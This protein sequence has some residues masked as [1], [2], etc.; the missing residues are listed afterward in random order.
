MICCSNVQII[1]G[2]IMLL[3][4][5][6]AKFPDKKPWDG[7]KK[8]WYDTIFMLNRPDGETEKWMEASE[9]PQYE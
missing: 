6:G 5:G 3:V 1:G 2:A 9:L 7:G 8:I 4:A